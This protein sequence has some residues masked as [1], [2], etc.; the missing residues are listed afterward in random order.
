[1]QS[2]II[3]SRGQYVPGTFFAHLLKDYDH[4][5]RQFQIVQADRGAIIFKVVKG[6]RYSEETLNQ[7]VEDAATVPRRG[8]GHQPSSSPRT[9]TM[10]RTGK[11]LATVSK[12][13]IDFQKD[14]GQLARRRSRVV[15]ERSCGRRQVRTVMGALCHSSSSSTWGIGT[16]Q[17]LLAP[18]GLSTRTRDDMATLM[19]RCNRCSRIHSLHRRTPAHRDARGAPRRTVRAVIGSAAIERE[20]PTGQPRALR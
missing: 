13:G 18:W 8:D 10:V 4:A 11:R 7:V 16:R 9:S 15:D 19:I 5:I 20:R 1:M 3:G 12:L 6:K 17:L 2:I 14:Q